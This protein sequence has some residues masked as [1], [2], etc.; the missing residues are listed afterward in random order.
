MST[1]VFS[2]MDLVI[3]SNPE[4]VRESRFAIEYEFTA[5]SGRGDPKT[6]ED[7]RRVFRANYDV[8]GAYGP[9]VASN[10]GLTWNGQSITWNDSELTWGDD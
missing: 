6:H 8:R 5:P 10:N 7:G 1:R 3:R 2:W 9:S 4:H